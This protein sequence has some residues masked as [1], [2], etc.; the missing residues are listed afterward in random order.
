MASYFFLKAEKDVGLQRPNTCSMKF[1]AR[2]HSGLWGSDSSIFW[3]SF[4]H[5]Y[6]IA[7]K[8]LFFVGTVTE[9]YFFVEGPWHRHKVFEP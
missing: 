3:P 9:V 7:V 8:S 5:K 4:C 6:K 1:V 2:G